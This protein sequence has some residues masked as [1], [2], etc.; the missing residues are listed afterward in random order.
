MSEILSEFFER[1]RDS[2]YSE[3]LRVEVIQSILEGLK[4]MVEEQVKGYP[5]SLEEASK[6]NTEP[7]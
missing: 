5:T 4:R 2:G 1:M 7:E 6:P 3:R